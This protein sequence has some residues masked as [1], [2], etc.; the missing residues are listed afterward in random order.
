MY[1]TEQG[2]RVNCYTQTGFTAFWKRCATH[3]CLPLGFC[4]TY[5]VLQ[6]TLMIISQGWTPVAERMTMLKG[7]AENPIQ[8]RGWY[9]WKL[10]VNEA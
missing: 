1:A 9:Y 4:L 7:F 2:S 8:E 10:T 3:K 6:F 5:I